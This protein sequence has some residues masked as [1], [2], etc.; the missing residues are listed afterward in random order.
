MWPRAFRPLGKRGGV[1]VC[2]DMC[3]QYAQVCAAHWPL[4]M[5]ASSLLGGGRRA[6]NVWVRSFP[7]PPWGHNTYARGMHAALPKW[8]RVDREQ[9]GRETGEVREG[10]RTYA[11]VCAQVCASMHAYARRHARTPSNKSIYGLNARSHISKSVI[12]NVRTVL[13]PLLP[14]Y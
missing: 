6:G 4:D 2:A 9:G 1:G 3:G 7:R 5:V 11:H 12:F 8:A 13:E 10:M 14:A